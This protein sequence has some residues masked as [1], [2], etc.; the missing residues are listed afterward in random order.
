MK[1]VNMSIIQNISDS[2]GVREEGCRAMAKRLGYLEW[3]NCRLV[4]TQVMATIS[5]WPAPAS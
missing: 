3:I 2:C 5:E 4:V 1:G